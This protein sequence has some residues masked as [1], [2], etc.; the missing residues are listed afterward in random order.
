MPKFNIHGAEGYTHHY[1]PRE[2]IEHGVFGSNMGNMLFYGSVYN[3]FAQKGENAIVTDRSIEQIN[4]A[5]YYLIPQA[6]LFYKYFIRNLDNHV[7]RLKEIKIPSVVVGI[8]YQSSVGVSSYGDESPLLN[9]SVRAFVTSVLEHSTSIG[10][11]GQVTKDYL[12]NLGFSDNEVD[13]IGCPSV[14]YFGRDFD[15]TIPEYPTFKP[16]MKIAVNYTPTRY[17]KAWGP[18]ISEILNNYPNTFAILQ[19]AYE[20]NNLR[21]K[22]PGIALPPIPQRVR[23][24]NDIPVKS[25]HTVFKENRSRIFTSPDIWM[26]SMK[27]FDFSIG[28]RIHGNIAAILAGTP[29]LVIAIDSRTLELAEYFKIPYVKMT[30]LVNYPTLEALY[31]KAI[32]DMPAFYINYPKT[33][34]DYLHFFRKNDIPV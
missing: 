5:D 20:V 24:L 13:V 11:R 31:D 8:G 25:S 2:V 3:T 34:E 28:T 7:E 23:K 6:N 1:S 27:T 21:W 18:R 26:H 19:D 10:V 16:G 15:L 33:L 12:L 14:R 30:E 32:E 17:D 22:F 29:A 9:E 4:A